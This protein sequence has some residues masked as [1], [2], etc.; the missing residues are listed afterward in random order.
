[1]EKLSRETLVELD[2][3]ADFGHIFLEALEPDPLPTEAVSKA[4]SLLYQARKLEL[5]CKVMQ[6]KLVSREAVKQR[7]VREVRRVRDA[8]LKLPLPLA[9][10]VAALGE[11][12]TEGQIGDVL[13][14]RFK[15]T[16]TELSQGS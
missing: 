15:Q 5:Q 6:G 13:T 11:D 2:F 16:F 8:F 1:M 12:A 14:R 3:T 7:I 4:K 9:E 10:E